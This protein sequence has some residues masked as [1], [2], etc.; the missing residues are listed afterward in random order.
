MSLALLLGL[1]LTAPLAAQ[2][3]KRPNVIFILADDLG[4]SDLGCYGGEI[5][6]PTLDQLAKDGLRF[7]QYYN[8]G[9]CWPSRAALLTGY[10]AQEVNRD[11]LPDLEGGGGGQL[12]KRPSWARLLPEYLKA[13]NYRSYHSGKWHIDGKVLDT[14]FDRSLNIDEKTNYFDIPKALVDDQFHPLPE[15]KG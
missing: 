10:I 12:N 7:T 3:T 2:E 13:A 1:M 14:G 8:T 15:T 11:Q 6:T 5:Q 9:R 4:Y